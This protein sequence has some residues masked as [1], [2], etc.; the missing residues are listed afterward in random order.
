MRRGQ[1]LKRLALVAV[2]VLVGFSFTGCSSKKESAGTDG[3]A[4]PA[5]NALAGINDIKLTFASPH[6]L[7]QS[8][9]VVDTE[10]I[11]RVKQLSGGKIE[12]QYFP[13]GTLIGIVESAAELAKG[14]ADLGWP[15]PGNNPN[16][17]PLYNAFIIFMYNLNPITD[18]EA[19][20]E[21]YKKVH[22]QYPEL[23]EEYIGLHPYA[24][25]AAG[26]SAYIF[27]KTP[28][29]SLADIRGKTIRA[30]GSW[31]K[32]VKALGGVAVNIPMSETYLALEKGTVDGTLGLPP[33][34][35]QVENLAEVV[36]YAMDIELNMSP[37]YSWAFNK[38]KWDSLPPEVQNFFNE[39]VDW[40]EDRVVAQLQSEVEP[41]IQYAKDHNVTFVTLPD[42]DR[43]QIYGIMDQI[44]RD[45]LKALDAKGL[46]AT[47]IYEYTQRLIAE[48]N[49][50]KK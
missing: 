1:A 25:N 30:T 44:N 21:I 26:T 28:I 3:A 32:V 42:S 6:T 8:Y 10:F 11:E 7:P 17:Y 22:A 19:E 48:Y 20:L 47:E 33:T 18:V 50:T 27:M 14:V 37:Y 13:G 38:D 9:A 45:S 36:S 15:R 49:A 23:Y 39:Q 35:L 41:S 31:G 24:A 4:A 43:A 2:A 29:A 5:S 46:R 40:L 12:L 16:G 34:T